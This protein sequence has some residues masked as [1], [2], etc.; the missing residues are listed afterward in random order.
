MRRR[1]RLD[2]GAAGFG[3]PGVGAAGF[4]GPAARVEM[5]VCRARPGFHHP[6]DGAEIM[7]MLASFGPPVVYG[8]RRIELRQRTAADPA[9]LAVAALEEPGVVVLF[10]QPR[11]PWAIVGR[12]D[13]DAERRLRR[14][15]AV[16]HATMALTRVDW[17]GR[18]LTDFLLFDGLM[19]EVGHHIV[20]HRA[21][22]TGVRAMRTADHE[23]RADAFATACRL[24]W[25]AAA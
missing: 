9:G 8:L 22:R 13:A 6:A 3:G 18:T 10:E 17:P 4:G 15:G 23:R 1:D 24:A 2:A 7:R 16:V 11:P 21:G 12:L 5:R 19:H 20:Q 25:T 14:A